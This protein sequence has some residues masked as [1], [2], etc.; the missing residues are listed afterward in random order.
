MSYAIDQILG[1][2]LP[3]LSPRRFGQRIVLVTLA[4]CAPFLSTQPLELD[5][6]RTVLVRL[7]TVPGGPLVS[8]DG[9]PLGTLL[10]DLPWHVEDKSID[11]LTLSDIGIG[12]KFDTAA[13]LYDQRQVMGRAMFVA[14]FELMLAKQQPWWPRVESLLEHA[15]SRNCWDT[16]LAGLP[17]P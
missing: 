2:S 8:L 7:L 16:M 12:A 14:A 4:D 11:E 13:M 17:E 15:A 3:R 9:T 1:N 10:V 6:L 5:E